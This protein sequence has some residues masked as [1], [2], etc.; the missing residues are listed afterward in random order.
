MTTLFVAI[1]GVVGVL[2]RWGITRLTFHTE[3]LLWST[4]GINIVGSFFL[5]LL[6]A[7]HWFGRDPPRRN[8]RWIPRRLYDVF[9]VLCPGRAGSGCGRAGT[10]G[11]LRA[12]IRGRRHPGRSRRLR[13]GPSAGLA[14]SCFL[15]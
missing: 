8:R 6:A 12:G 15:A 7:E 13:P 11:C 4:V 5:G 14:P 10:S 2:A 1:G 9:D 3:A